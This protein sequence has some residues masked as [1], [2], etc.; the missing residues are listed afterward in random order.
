MCRSPMAEFIARRLLAEHPVTVASAGTDAVDGCP[1][2]RTRSTSRPGPAPTPPA[3][4]PG[5]CARNT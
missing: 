4:A 3:S 5:S 2:T 1:C